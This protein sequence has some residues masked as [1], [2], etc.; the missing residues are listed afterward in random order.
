MGQIAAFWISPSGNIINA[1]VNHIDA[2]IKNPSKFGIKSSYINNL[3]NKYL[4]PIGTEG[5]ARE[6]II[7]ELINSGW[8]RIRRYANKFW[9][10]NVKK[11]DKKTKDYLSQ[12]AIDILETGIGG[13][14]EKDKYFPVKI[15]IINGKNIE[16]DIDDVA[17]D[18]LYS[19][20]EKIEKYNNFFVLTEVFDWSEM[21]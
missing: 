14:K 7:S 19:V 18:G 8:I 1:G 21:I 5:K 13:F 16:L 17:N 9:S 3:Y 15:D 6:N 20:R 11:L 4:E 2:V 10:V 12:W